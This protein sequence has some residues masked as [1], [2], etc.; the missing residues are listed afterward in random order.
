M[1]DGDL[2]ILTADHGNDPSWVGTD[3]TRERVP[4]LM[5]AKGLEPGSSGVRSTFADIGE[6]AAKWLNLPAGRHGTSIL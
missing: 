3:H 2:L 4:V 6:T 1:K 5:T